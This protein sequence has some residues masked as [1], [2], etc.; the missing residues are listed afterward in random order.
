MRCYLMTNPKTAKVI[1][2][3]INNKVKSKRFMKKSRVNER[4]FTRSRKMPFH[5]LIYFML[6]S[7]KQTLQKEL[8]SFMSVF[9]KH[10]N[11]TKSAFCQQ[12]L[13][14]RPEAFIELND[15]LIKEF[16]TDNVVEQWNDFRLLCIDSSTLELPKSQ[17]V[18]DYFGVNNESNQI[19]IA[20]ISTLFDLLNEFIL[21]TSIA[22]N[23]SSEYDLAIG[24]L[25]KIK[26]YNLIIMDRGYGARWLFY[27]LLER[28]ADFVVRL[29]HGFGE[30][31]D[32]FWNSKGNSKIIE[33]KE[34]PPKSEQ[35]LASMNIKSQPF[36]FRVVKVILDNG[37]VEVLA[38]SLLDADKYPIEIFK[39]LYNKR[40]GVE[41][42]YSH[43]K[44][45]IEIG[46]FTGFSTQV[47]KQDF[48]ANAFIANIQ[49]LIIRDAQIELNPKVEHRKY[50]YKINRNLSLGY[51][52]DRIIG[53]LASDNPSYYDEL[54]KL[55]Q[56]EPVP[57]RKDR[58]FPRKKQRWKRKYYLNQK[59]AL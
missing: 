37:E 43:L 56:I 7:I 44:N 50:D 29:Q 30:D 18:I 27:L 11:I 35:R 15:M 40:W 57:I 21:D 33:V 51:M 34:L 47:I 42:S 55:F 28:K 5:L 45:H 59:R 14:L 1:L 54:V 49:R 26:A 12:R 3:K 58:K 23:L 20:K 24:H 16:Y 36:K 22:P 8:T 52:K 41:T 38:T 39:E 4:D 25:N 13:K 31:V 19:P 46:N 10:S 9:T 32:E 6:N 48:F 53:L 2:D 17:E